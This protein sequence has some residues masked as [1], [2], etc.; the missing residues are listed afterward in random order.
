MRDFS[1]FP[2]YI[3]VMVV[4]TI[5]NDMILYVGVEEIA[6]MIDHASPMH[7]IGPY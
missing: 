2:F 4:A 1:V 7:V 5:Q 6:A 3:I